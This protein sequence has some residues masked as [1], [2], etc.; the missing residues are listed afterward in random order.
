MCQLAGPE[1]ISSL[2]HTAPLPIPLQALTAV[3]MDAKS[4]YASWISRTTSAGA[5]CSQ[6]R[7]TVQPDSARAAVCSASRAI[8]SSIFG[9]Q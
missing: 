7:N 9:A 8:V 5:S 3:H 1:I 2:F 4:T 6:N